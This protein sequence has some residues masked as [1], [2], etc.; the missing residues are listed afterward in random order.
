MV[1]QKQPL[2][3]SQQQDAAGGS[4][5]APLSPTWV[6]Q[7]SRSPASRV[8]RVPGASG[9]SDK[10]A[11]REQQQA[12][13]GEAVQPALQTSS[14]ASSRQ[15][16][17]AERAP[18]RA[19]GAPAAVH[20]GAAPS[21]SSSQPKVPSR[22]GRGQPA[23]AASRRQPPPCK[24]APVSS[25]AGCQE[26]TG[27]PAGPSQ[28]QATSSALPEA[29]QPAQHEGPSGLKGPAATPQAG[30]LRQQEEPSRRQEAP[31]AAQT[32]HGA[33]VLKPVPATPAV[34]PQAVQGRQLAGEAKGVPPP[35]REVA[36]AARGPQQ[37]SSPAPARPA[38]TAEAGQ[39][40]QLKGCPKVGVAPKPR[41]PHQVSSTAARANRGAQNG[42]ARSSP[43]PARP[44][45]A[46]KAAVAVAPG[47]AVPRQSSSARQ[48]TQPAA[49]PLPATSSQQQPS[50]K[51]RMRRV[52][53][54]IYD[55]VR[56]SLVSSLGR[57]EGP[58][59]QA[60]PAQAE[61]GTPLPAG[62]EGPA[63]TT[64]PE[65]RGSSLVRSARTA[66]AEGCSPQPVGLL[67]QAST[68][69]PEAIA[70]ASLPKMAAGPRRGQDM[71]EGLSETIT[72]TDSDGDSDTKPASQGSSHSQAARG[73][74]VGGK[75]AM[76]VA[77]LDR[78]MLLQTITDPKSVAV[79]HN[80]R[81]RAAVG[82]RWQVVGRINV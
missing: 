31:L 25:P 13:R 42:S 60:P 70:P 49:T 79:M 56:S 4:L 75:W 72:I 39:A 82:A 66:K 69:L 23:A 74:Q 12:A 80:H 76:G 68:T 59:Q 9:G 21:G 47:P 65:G 77:G 71:R 19:V 17:A 46:K 63:Q 24:E 6:G 43:A 10:S 33:S 30:L 38:A 48:V 44:A 27:T 55:P 61:A 67:G 52:D 15:A 32:S 50:A 20:T 34:S 40:R 11:S 54:L 7:R 36:Q 73:R 81:R 22:L 45:A 3:A 37:S 51:K 2:P 16:A 64:T 1:G 26:D 57:A 41:G 35:V 58:A 28:Q 14:S 78:V 53:T 8:G 18:S 5:P 62:P 29:G